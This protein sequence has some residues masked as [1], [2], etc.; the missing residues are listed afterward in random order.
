MFGTEGR[1]DDAMGIRVALVTQGYQ[2]AGGI[3]TAARWL[4]S[5]LVD[6]GHTVSIF[7]LATSRR[8]KNSRRAMSIKSWFRS[9]LLSFDS[10]ELGVVHV[11]ANVVEIEP[12]RYLPR[13]ELTTA[14]KRF[15]IVQVVS[16]GAALGLCAVRSQ[17][18]IILQVA[19]RVTWERNFQNAQNNSVSALRRR[20]ISTV[21]SLLEAAALKRASCVLVMNPQMSEYASA[22]GARNVILAPPGIDTTFFRPDPKGWNQTG[23]LLSVCRFNDPRKG[24]DRLIRAYAIMLDQQPNVPPLVLAGRGALPPNLRQLIQSIGVA[25]RTTILTD[26]PQAKLPSLYQEASVYM[27][28][29][30]E[31]GLGISILEAMSCGIP[32]VSTS[33]AGTRE[34][35]VHGSTGWLL[36][37]GSAVEG[38]LANCVLE[39]L[40]GE[41][42]D[43]SIA[44]RNRAVSHFSQDS[45]FRQITE[46][47]NLAIQY[48]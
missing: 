22:V 7:D 16:G 28:A 24:L 32:V 12:M 34:T 40:R 38:G 11:G 43:M 3:Q 46:E 18:P 39:V 44:A 8:D 1:G 35:M 47:Y 26:V 42:H 10:H 6:A 30:Y 14:L 17:V 20:L 36:P 45:K 19:T 25:E 37:Q 27:Q 48:A 41:G 15:D 5:S 2:T 13:G 29:S 33:T 4:A 31:E 9:S 21:I 23:Y